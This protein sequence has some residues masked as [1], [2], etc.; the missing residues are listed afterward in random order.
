MPDLKAFSRRV[1]IEGD[2]GRSKR[3]RIL[4]DDLDL[5]GFHSRYDS[6]VSVWI[7]AMPVENKEVAHLRFVPAG[8]GKLQ[9][10]AA[11]INTAVFDGAVEKVFGIA[12]RIGHFMLIVLVIIALHKLHALVG[13]PDVVT[14]CRGVAFPGMAHAAVVVYFHAVEAVEHLADFVLRVGIDFSQ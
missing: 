2:A 7:A 4:L 6:H 1:Q 12:I 5:A 13:N 9:E 3:P 11:F 10:V 14:V 8:V